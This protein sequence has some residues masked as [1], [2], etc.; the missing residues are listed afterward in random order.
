MGRSRRG[1]SI[2][3]FSI[4]AA[5]A[6]GRSGCRSTP[7]ASP[8]QSFL[9]RNK[10]V[11]IPC[12]KERRE[13]IKI[14]WRKVQTWGHSIFL[15]PYISSHEYQRKKERKIERKKERKREREIERKI[16]FTPKI[17]FSIITQLQIFCLFLDHIEEAFLLI[18]FFVEKRKKYFNLQNFFVF[19]S[20]LLYWINSKTQIAQFLNVCNLCSFF[21]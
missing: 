5:A 19:L 10:S 6:D 15:L 4:A 8:K 11:F 20:L 12:P 14:K 9:R 13:R 1:F 16:G 3:A 17:K 7:K 18:N 2:A 21:V